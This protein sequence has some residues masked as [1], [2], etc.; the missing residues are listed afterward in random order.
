M[1]SHSKIETT[2][3]LKEYMQDYWDILVGVI[4]I[5]IAFYLHKIGQG[6]MATLMAA[7]GI[8]ALS[9]TVSEVAEILSERLVEPYASMVLTFSAVVVEIV[10]LYIILLEAS[11]SPEVVET[12][13]G[14]GLSLLLS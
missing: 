2:S 10:L 7:I 14:G 12:V 8:A 4:S 3:N 6:G 1:Q 9:L 11:H 5:I 13:K